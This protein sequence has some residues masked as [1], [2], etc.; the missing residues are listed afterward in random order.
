MRVTCRTAGAVCTVAAVVT[1]AGLAPAVAGIKPTGAGAPASGR[2]PA[3]PLRPGP[4]SAVAGPFSRPPTTAQCEARFHVACYDPGQIQAAYG[5]PKLYRAGVDGAGQ[6]IVIVDTF[7]SPT[8]RRDLR[9]FD[10]TF[11]LRPPPSLK[12]IQPAGKVPPYKPTGDRIGSAVETTLDVEYAHTAAPGANILL[13]ETPAAEVEGTT[14]FRPIV[15]AEKYVINHHLGGVISQSFGATEQ[16]FPSAQALLRLR[17]AYKDARAKGVT[18]LAS[19]G[20]SGATDYKANA[21]SY[22]LHPVTSW[23]DSDP[24]VTGVGG[25]QLHLNP[26]GRHIAPDNVWNDTY[27]VPANEQAFGDRG[28]NPLASGGGKSV[29]F[30]RPRYQDGVKS[31]VG[32]ARG[33]P[34][35]SMSA[36]CNGAVN[37]YLSFRGIPPGWLQLCGTSEASPLFAGIVSLADQVA[38]HPLGLINPALYQLSAEHAPG[39]VDV[40]SGNNTVSL[41]QNG[42]LHTVKGFTARP[43]YDLASGVGTVYAPDFVPELAHTAG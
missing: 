25:T 17:G 20:D 16:T 37:V 36:A 3:L 38:G 7:G 13:V 23:P 12:I 43:G 42:K 11:G 10:K 26:A 19:S 1:L 21:S 9:V 4:V 18:V 30:A 39:I 32:R 5:L 33:V 6:T 29:I 28:P 24:L 22:Y 40:T 41:T 35:I 31:V 15:Q 2:S 8:I 14:G 27:N 34:D